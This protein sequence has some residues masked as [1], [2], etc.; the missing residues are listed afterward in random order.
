MTKALALTGQ[1][2]ER[3]TVIKRMENN[4]HGSSVWLCKC[5]CGNVVSVVGHQLTRHKT[6]SC[7][8]LRIDKLHITR[9]V[10]KRKE[11]AKLSLT[12]HGGAGTRLYRVYCGMIGR[13]CYESHKSYPN[14]GGRGIKVCDNWRED[15][16]AFQ[17]WA[18]T[19]GYNKNAPYGQCTLDRI[20]VNGDYCPENCRWAD[21]KTQ[22]NNKRITKK[23][24]P[25]AE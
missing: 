18:L 16:G 3:L 13:C 15:F 22:A 14:Y 21:A 17:Q 11:N 23:K 5:E 6:K 7:G 8:C 12:T 2:F 24:D 1:K 19:N 4:K 9:E 10:S 20:D 25:P